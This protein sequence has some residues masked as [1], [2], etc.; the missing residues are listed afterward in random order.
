MLTVGMI[1]LIVLLY[2]IWVFIF[3][4]LPAEEEVEHA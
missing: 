2:R 3:P 4:V 1:S